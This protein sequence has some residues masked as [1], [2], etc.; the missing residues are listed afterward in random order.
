MHIESNTKLQKYTHIHKSKSMYEIFLNDWQ[1]EK[2][3]G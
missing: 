3:M 1:N 2:E